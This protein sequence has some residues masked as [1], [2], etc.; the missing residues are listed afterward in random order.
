MDIINSI[1][2]LQP[3]DSRWISFLESNTDISIFYHPAWMEV[4]EESYGYHP[5]VLALADTK[6]RVIAGVPLMEVNSPVKGR[7]WVSLP[8]TDYCRPL[9]KD[10]ETLSVFTEQLLREV[11]RK[12][13][14]A[15]E[16]RGTYPANQ[17]LDIHSEHVLH[18]LELTPDISVVWNGLH[19]MHRR[20]IKIATENHV[21]IVQGVAN[22]HLA[23]FY[24][25]HLLT[26]RRQGVPVQPWKF[27][28]HLKKLLIDQGQGFLLLAYKNHECIAGAVFLNWQDTLTYKYGASTE[29][30]LK[31]RPN[32]LIMWSAI[33]EACKQGFRYFDM[34]RTDLD[35]AG[36][37]MFKSRWGAKEIPL[38]YSNLKAGNNHV[39]QGRLSRYMNFVIQNSPTFVC[40]FTGELLYKHFG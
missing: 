29:D 36:L 11:E 8:F 39:A 9:C 10:E 3:S 6:D 5:F 26:R 7:R 32:N 19:S 37:R 34:G 38:F 18:K 27:F 28:V 25:L 35:N 13:I 16:L 23:E 17:S 14:P 15:L 24:R 31:Y 40:R 20:N 22:E 12:Q 30:G 1:L 33:K 2:L 4:M 21:E